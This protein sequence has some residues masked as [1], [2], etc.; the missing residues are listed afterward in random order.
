[1]AVIDFEIHDYGPQTRLIRDNARATVERNCANCPKK[2]YHYWF[3][4][5]HILLDE[6]QMLPLCFECASKVQKWAEKKLELT[7]KK[8]L[9]AQEE[10]T[11]IVSP[12]LVDTT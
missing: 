12:R 3:W 11:E 8:K 9:K 7:P 5:A 1:M 10:P 2:G 6:Y 4:Y